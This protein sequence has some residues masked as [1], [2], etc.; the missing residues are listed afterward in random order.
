MVLICTSLM[1]SAVEHL[2]FHI[3]IN[4]WHGHLYIFGE[5]PIQILCQFLNKIILKKLLSCRSSLC[6]LDINPLQD[7]MCIYFLPF[8]RLLFLSVDCVLWCIDIFNFDDQVI[9]FFF[10]FLCFWCHI[11]EIIPKSSVW[12]FTPIF[13]SKCFIVLGLIFGSLMH[14]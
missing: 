2:F 12:G 10:R 13:S 3:W 4:K 14:F 9:Y 7:M 11:Q 1:I 8:H 5:M 6:I